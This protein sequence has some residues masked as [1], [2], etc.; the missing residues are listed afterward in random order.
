M[1]G[2]PLVEAVVTYA[3]MPPGMLGP[4]AQTLEV[5]CFVVPAAS[6]I[7]LVDAG[8]PGTAGAIEATLQR[9]GGGWSEVTDI[10]LT[11]AHFDHFG[12]LTEVT[13]QAPK[14][15]VWA[16]AND[17]PAVQSDPGTIIRPLAEGDR[18]GD[19][20]VLDTPGHTPGHLGLLHE[21][22]SLIL[23]GDLVGSVDGSVTFGP[24]AFTADPERSRVSLERVVQMG[25]D[26]LLFSHGAEVDAPNDL[27]RALLETTAG[28]RP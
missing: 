22:G 8:L 9:I 3:Q 21:A 19:L 28:L 17:V 7:V 11:H 23:V 5:R 24:P 10:V 27:A 6:G 15:A 25:V 18:V 2:P 12:G 4:D 16:G 13:A 26:R 1:A 20:V 14:A